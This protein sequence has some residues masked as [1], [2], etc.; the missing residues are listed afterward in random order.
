MSLLLVQVEHGAVVRRWEDGQVVPSEQLLR[1]TRDW[2]ALKIANCIGQ[3]AMH[4]LLEQLHHLVYV[5]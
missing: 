5:P 2:C 3:T 4:S 1:A